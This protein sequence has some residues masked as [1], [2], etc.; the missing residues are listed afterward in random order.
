MAVA[1]ALGSN[2][3]DILFGL[4]LP[5]LIKTLIFDLDSTIEVQ[6][7]GMLVSCFVIFMLILAMLA[8]LYQQEYNLTKKLGFVL[9]SSYGVF[10][11]ISV[12]MELYV[13]GE[14]HLPTCK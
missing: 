9:L 1:Q 10:L 14:Y 13:W 12:L 7:V 6:S 5:W 4:G 11:V 2:V 3:F 8:A